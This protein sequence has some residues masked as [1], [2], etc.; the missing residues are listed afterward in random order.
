MEVFMM[1]TEKNSSLFQ[2]TAKKHYVHRLVATHFLDNPNNLR[3]VHHIDSNP[4]N[5]DISNL[6]W[7]SHQDNC[8]LKP[9]IHPI[10][11]IKKR[12]NAY[13]T[14]MDKSDRYIFSYF[15]S[16]NNIPIHKRSFKT[17]E[18]AIEYRDMFFGKYPIV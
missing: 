17:K 13:V 6:Q 2:A 16:Y 9:K 10:Y 8:R 7:L 15:G 5:N 3:D 1:L 4:H 14:K 12:Q 11:W 18:G